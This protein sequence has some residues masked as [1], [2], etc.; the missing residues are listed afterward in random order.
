MAIGT[1]E[2][3]RASDRPT[4]WRIARIVEHARTSRGDISLTLHHL[5]ELLET[6]ESYLGVLF[7][8][9]TGLNFRAF[10]REIRITHA[11]ELLLNRSLS[12]KYIASIT[13]YKSPASFN[14]DFK[15]IVG[16][17]PQKYRENIFRNSSAG[18][19]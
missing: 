11:R 16:M 8:K 9:S 14:R 12:V 6:S 7:R 1:Y 5:S 3:R 2:G 13:T 18:T 15:A 17:S 10:L 19:E 4:D